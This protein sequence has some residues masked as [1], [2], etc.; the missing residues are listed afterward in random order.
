MSG[1]APAAA[2]APQHFEVAENGRGYRVAERQ[3]RVAER[4]EGLMGAVFRI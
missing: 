4:Q 1:F 2:R 3:D